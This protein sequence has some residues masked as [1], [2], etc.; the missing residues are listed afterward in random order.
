VRAKDPAGQIRL[1][2]ESAP[3]D[4]VVTGEPS[5]LLLWLWGRRPDASINATGTSGS[6]AELRS[7]LAHATQ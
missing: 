2:R 7:L 5:E 3:A 1:R 4:A 6:A